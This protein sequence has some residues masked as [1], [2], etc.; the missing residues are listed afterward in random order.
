MTTRAA[1]PRGS[2]STGGGA[3]RGAAAGDGQAVVVGSGPNGL[4]AAVALARAGLRVTVLE[5]A[6][7]PGGGT[8]S[9]AATLPG[10]LHDHC[11]GV[12]PLGAASAYWN[13]LGLERHGLVWKHAE[14]DLAHPLDGGRAGLLGRG[15]PDGGLDGVEERDR[16]AWARTVGMIGRQFDE[17]AADALG[18]LLRVPRHPVQ[19]ARF[20][21]LA[22]LPAA[23]L[24]RAWRGEAA[25][26]LFAGCA[27]HGFQALEHPFT[28][29]V[30]L[31][32]AASAHAYGWPVAQGGSQ[33]IAAAL[34]AELREHGGQVHTG[35][36][37]RSLRELP[38]AQVVMLDTAP[39]AAADICGDAMPAAVAR[40]YRR[41]RHGPAAFKLDLAVEGGVPWQAEG[42]RRAGTVHVGGTL[43][44][45]AAAERD[46]GR[47]RLPERPFVLVAQQY[48][49]DPGRSAGNVHPVYAY[50][51]VPHGWN[52]DPAVVREAVLGQLERFAP[53]LRDRVLAV[54]D[55]TP[56]DFAAFDANFVGG[57]I[58]T[59]A[60]TVRQ[61]LARPRFAPDPYATGVPGVH[62]CSA[63]TPPG[64]GAHGLCGYHAAASALRRL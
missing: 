9:G 41:W 58:A 30:G 1:V 39:A 23:V 59:G 19:V 2:R 13:S 63:A 45:I 64:A 16:R 20:G 54:H 50:A 33:A 57:D 15:L 12:H 42:A 60:T 51:H 8:R 24:G 28:S 6:D 31:V 5:A 48:L 49:A 35:V 7:E 40:A 44:E 62:L 32:L 22:A 55:S 27:A 46:A 25:R 37:V 21:A 34:I 4:T 61:L 53:G 17:V 56:A 18:P 11:S 3:G 10:L 43:A 47:G 52:G 38:P 29:S 26:A 14:I 36:R